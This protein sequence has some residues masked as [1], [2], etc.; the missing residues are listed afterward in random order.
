MVTT[1][2]KNGSTNGINSDGSHASSTQPYNYLHVMSPPTTMNYGE[3]RM[4]HRTSNGRVWYQTFTVPRVTKKPNNTDISV[5]VDTGN[6]VIPTNADPARD[7]DTVEVKV[8]V[9]GTLLDEDI[10][11]DDIKR[12]TNYCRHDVATWQI[13]L[14]TP[15]ANDA[16]RDF[17]KEYG[18]AGFVLKY[19]ISEIK[20]MPYNSTTKTY[21]T[22]ITARE[23]AV[24]VDNN[25]SHSREAVITLNFG[26]DVSIE[27]QPVPQ[28]PEPGDPM[29]APP[30]IVVVP[31][32]VLPHPA[33]DIVPYP[34]E[35]N[36]D[37]SQ[38]VKREV[39]VNRKK[40]DDDY[41][42]S[43][44]YV[45][46][47]GNHGLTRI[48][49]YYTS[50]D[51]TGSL[52][53]RWIYV[54]DTKPRA[55]FKL[56]GSY[57][58]NRRMKLSDRSPEAIDEPVQSRYPINGYQWRFTAVDG[59]NDYIKMR[60]ISEIYK[61]LLFKEPGTY[62]IELVV[63]NTLGR[64][65]DPVTLTFQVLEDYPAA[66]ICNL[67]NSVLQ[68]DEEITSYA[69]DAAS[70][71][72]DSI[73]S[74]RL[75]LFYDS[76][77]NGNYDRLL[78]TWNDVTEFPVY[79]ASQ[80]GRYKYVITIREAFGEETLPEFV[81]YDDRRV[82]VVE[83]EFAVD[84]C[85]PM[86]GIYVDIPIVR[87]EV[88][89]YIVM[90]RSLDEAK[91]SYLVNNRMSIENSM[92]ALNII[93]RVELWDLHT[94][95][96]SQPASTAVN[97]GTAY[98]SETVEHSSNGYSGVLSRTSI[99]DNGSYMDFGEY[100]TRTERKTFTASHSNTVTN[101]WSE[102]G[103]LIRTTDSSPAP[104]SKSINS[105]GYHGSIP[106]TGTTG[107]TNQSTTYWP[108]GNKKTYKRTYT[109]HYSGTL[110]KTVRYWDPDWQW[111]AD[112]TGFYSGTIQ[113]DV[114]QPYTDPYRPTSYKYIIYISDDGISEPD[115]LQSALSKADSKLILVGNDGIKNQA[116]HDYFIQNNKPINE[117]MDDALN[118]IAS[119]CQAIEKYYVLAGHDTFTMNTADYDEENDTITERKLQYVHNPNYFDNPTGM[120]A[121]AADSFSEDANWVDNKVDRF[122]NTGEF[123]I[124]RRIRD[125]PSTEAG[126][127]SYS[128]YSGTQELVIYS[129]RK[130]IALATLDWDYD[131][132]ENT[133]RTKWVD[134][135]YDLDHQYSRQ[136]KGIVDRK[137]MYRAAGGEWN[138]NIP[139][140]LA[141]GTYELRYYVR[142]PEGAWSDP[143]NMDFTL[144]DFPG[145]QFD[146][147]LRSLE[148]SFSLTSIPAS[149]HLEAFSLWTRYPYNVYLEMA[150]FRGAER[151]SPLKTVYFDETTGRKEDN[152]IYWN[153]IDYPIPNTLR[154]GV[155]TFG[156][157]AVDAVNPGIRA[158]KH[159][160]VMVN[161]PV[162]LRPSV[163]E[164]TASGSLFE[165]GAHTS[166]YADNVRVTLFK[167][168]GYE[169]ALGMS[170]ASAADGDKA[171]AAAYN[172]P[173]EVPDGT[174]TAE[175]RAA[176]PNGNAETKSVEFVIESLKITGATI[177]GYWNHWRGQKDIFGEQL[178]D[179]P[180]RF[181]SMETVKINVFTT[182]FADR[183]VI[184]FSPELE[185][186]QFTDKYGNVYNYA[187][188]FGHYVSFP[189]DSTFILDNNL[190]DNHVY[191][192]YTLPLAQSTKS[193]DNSRLRG[194]YRMTVTAYKGDKTDVLEIGDIDITGNVYDLTYIQPIN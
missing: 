60:D 181:L 194:H 3:G 95:T 149:E 68:R 127:S 29:T 110:S 73:A 130:P 134:L 145:I 23:Q 102:T 167:G 45:F 28:R 69:Y 33:F 162:N 46:G 19:K 18:A 157:S 159:F 147:D 4:W 139:G 121:I 179:E 82:K 107:P 90:D 24:Y 71:D 112:Y 35:D 156:I 42:F 109:A 88:D 63:S 15:K 135:S 48:D 141:P 11:E 152:D 160:A 10:Y 184:R 96:Y 151:V 142:D 137:I 91:V 125:C 165:L 55:Q 41:F 75:E 20:A 97:T 40:V 12:V 136:D 189:E 132:D 99:S 128:Y 126:F 168:T 34:A 113:K 108:N 66:V 85:L 50:V 22:T 120:E 169:V 86:T 80:L 6:I 87:P 119:S 140:A 78:N 81:L 155:Y 51:G 150:L 176:T 62:K 7:N 164:R 49:V 79:K 161:T 166:K 182:G 171:W 44:G 36:T 144:G 53:T 187:D 25:K 175:F 117:L 31:D 52:Q 185:A 8:S 2:P 177:E 9:K 158:N 72:G 100:K 98:P 174:Y 153:N 123:R 89:A 131:P 14:S 17:T 37:M 114:S 43:G 180:H 143:F 104:S 38:C 163:P 65:S 133:Y 172:I 93:P 111:V 92:R 39:F 76:D 146:A 67:N 193:W 58:Q 16:N 1:T 56:E 26:G 59:S 173:G 47:I 115:L 101:Y 183:V 186:M 83:R 154:D 122:E 192:E 94:Y 21:Y 190:M 188:Y 77:N 148:D 13:T 70:T 103:S 27:P 124:F 30:P 64:V 106:R 5:S 105:D 129:H 74:S 170:C 32:C 84:N 138:Y 178:A 54:Y 191:W 61:E 57:K 118:V 116:V